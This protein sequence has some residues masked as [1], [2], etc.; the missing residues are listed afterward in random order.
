MG[1]KLG[2]ISG[3]IADIIQREG[4]DYHQ[5][6]AVF[7]DALKNTGVHTPTDPQPQKSVQETEMDHLL[8][9]EFWCNPNFAELFAVACDLQFETFQVLGATPEPPL[10]SDGYGDLLV[11]AD[12]DG[13]RIGL[14]IEDKITAGTPP[15][16]AERYADYAEHLRLNGWDRV[17]TVLVAPAAYRGERDQYEAS[18]DLEEVAEMIDSPDPLRRDYRRNII[19]R[20]LEKKE[21]IGVQNPDPVLHRIHADYR[22]WVKERHRVSGHPYE[23]PRLEKEYH[24]KDVWIDKI[25]HPDFPNHIWLRHRFWTSQKAATGM[26]DLIISPATAV[27]REHL[28]AAAPQEAIISTYGRKK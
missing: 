22:D 20:A 10:G 13:Q 4:V 11:E 9:E 17:I 6:K 26:V 19:K 2:R 8:A 18:V 23:F 7:R 15:R 14:L 12:M 16:Q 21:R 28:H 27:L 5:A 24:D 1:D 3:E 25:R